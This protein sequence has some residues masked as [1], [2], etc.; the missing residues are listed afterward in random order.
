MEQFYFDE[1]YK[2]WNKNFTIPWVSL[3]T[4]PISCCPMETKVEAPEQPPMAGPKAGLT[5][6][7]KEVE[8]PEKRAYLPPPGKSEPRWE[9]LPAQ[10]I[11]RFYCWL[12]VAPVDDVRKNGR[13]ADL[14]ACSREMTVGAAMKPEGEATPWAATQ[15]GQQLW[16]GPNGDLPEGSGP[17]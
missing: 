10:F 1:G 8:S 6:P 2:H 4:E 7:E 12:G 11:R 13:S 5:H 15:Q 14:K 17:H 16:K 3:I 9:G